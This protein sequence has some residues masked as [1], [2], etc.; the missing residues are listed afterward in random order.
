[1]SREV[2]MLLFTAIFMLG[3]VAVPLISILVK[4][5]QTMAR[6]LRDS[7]QSDQVENQLAAMRNEISQ[8]NATIGALKAASGAHERS[9]KELS[10]RL[11]ERF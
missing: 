6:I 10:A 7:N 9:D 3:C 4:H 1:M 8:L 2:G 11:G 5:Q